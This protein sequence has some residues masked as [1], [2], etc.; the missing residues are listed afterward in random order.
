MAPDPNA[1]AAHGGLAPDPI[2]AGRSID[3]QPATAG[4]GARPQPVALGGEEQRGGQQ[5][6]GDGIPAPGRGSPRAVRRE[7]EARRIEGAIEVSAPRVEIGQRRVGQ[8][9]DQAP[10][11]AEPVQLRRRGRSSWSRDGMAGEERLGVACRGQVVV[12]RLAAPRVAAVVRRRP[13]GGVG[14]RQ[15]GVRPEPRGEIADWF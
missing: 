11:R 15:R 1:I 13:M 5:V 12:R 4:V 3:E 2:P 10:D 7:P 14:E 9:P 6:I 8:G